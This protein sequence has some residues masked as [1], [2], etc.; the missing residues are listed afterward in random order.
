MKLKKLRKKIDQIDK[1]L[2]ELLNQRAEEVIQVSLL[3]KAKKLSLYSP[4]REASLLKNLKKI[5]SGPL[6]G[7]D[8]ENIFREIL[9]ACRSQ[10]HS[11]KV[12][13]L[14]PQG[15][16]THLAAIKKFGK[17][18]DF[19]PVGTISDVFESVDK[20]QAEYGVV[21]IENSTEGVINYTLDMFFDS[22][23]NICAEATLNIS[24]ALLGRNLKSIKRIYSNPQVFPQCRN[25]VGRYL[26][27]AE[28]VPVSSTAKAAQEAK[29]DHRGAC[30]GNKILANLY[31]LKVLASSIED[32]S[33]N[34]TRFLVIARKDSPPSGKDKTSILFSIKDRVGALHDILASFK[35]SGINL[36]KIESRPSKKKAWEYYFF[37]DFQGHHNSPSVQ[38]ALKKLAR[39]CSF[40]KILG[41]YPREN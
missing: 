22:N 26:K 1:R 5:D 36:T 25:W 18:P 6:A 21:P 2:V 35:E 17:K 9:S 38:K 24:H 39:R 7:E 31:G 10:R 11:L 34:Y 33:N 27:G 28:L 14:G 12:A 23:L 29:K 40:V 3:K 20:Q 41:S 16:F 15:T 4:E 30:I 37:V 8:I 32:L 19:I 13:Y